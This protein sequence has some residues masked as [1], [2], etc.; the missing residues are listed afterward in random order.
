MQSAQHGRNTSAIE[1]TNISPHGF[2]LLIGGQ[3]RFVSFKEFPRFREARIA[4][5]T[6]VPPPRITFLL[7]PRTGK[8]THY[9]HFLPARWKR[10]SGCDPGRVFFLWANCGL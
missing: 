8:G 7:T 6:H 9:L 2:W 5:L 3:E 10:P 4:A 1:V